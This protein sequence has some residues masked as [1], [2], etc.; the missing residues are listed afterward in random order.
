MSEGD[1]LPI[2]IF[3]LSQEDLLF[4]QN[5][6]KIIGGRELGN[7]FEVVVHRIGGGGRK[8]RQIFRKCAGEW[9]FVGYV[10]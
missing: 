4:F 6:G 7:F 3:T 2:N 5:L 9:K 10:S 1:F 8:H